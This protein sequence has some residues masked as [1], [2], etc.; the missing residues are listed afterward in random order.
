M[1]TKIYSLVL[2]IVMIAIVIAIYFIGYKEGKNSILDEIQDNAV[3]GIHSIRGG[4]YN[5]ENF[6]RKDSLK[7]GTHK[8]LMTIKYTDSVLTWDY[9]KKLNIK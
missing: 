5:N 3:F 6:E 2:Y 4:H 1:K 8:C 9:E 7:F